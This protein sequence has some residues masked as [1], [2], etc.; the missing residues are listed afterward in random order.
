M[1]LMKHVTC[2]NSH[3]RRSSVQRFP[4]PEEKIPWT[5]D[6][7]DYDPIFYESPALAGK[8]W[9]DPAIGKSLE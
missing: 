5:T 3:Y 1:K 2:I 8:E 4:V 7:H 6:Y 9:A